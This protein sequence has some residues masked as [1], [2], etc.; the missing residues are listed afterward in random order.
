MVKELSYNESLVCHLLYKAYLQD[1]NATMTATDLCRKTRILK[2][3]MNRTLN[4][5]EE[6]GYITRAR[7]SHDRRKVNIRM[8]AEQAGRFSI[9]H[10]NIIAIVDGVVERVGEDAS[11]KSIDVLNMLC[12]AVEVT[13]RESRPKA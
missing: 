12:D 3:Q 9:Q 1:P 6:R 11:S 2:S 8:T 13:L 4:R 7:D 10:D 5:L